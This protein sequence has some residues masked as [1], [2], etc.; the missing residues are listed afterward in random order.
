MRDWYPNIK[1]HFVIQEDPR[2]QS[3]AIYLAREHLTGPMMVVFAD[4]L[5]ETDLSFLANETSDAIAWVKPVDDPRRF[6]VVVLDQQGGVTRL[7]EKPEET[8][9]NLAVVGFYYFRSSKQLISA[10]EEQMRRDTQL[11]GE[12]FLV[13]AVNIMLENGL[14]MR[15]EKVD[16]WLDAGTPEALLE[17]NRYLLDN[18]HS[19]SQEVSDRPGTVIIPP[20]YLHPSAEVENSIIGPHASIGAGARVYSS[21]VRNSILED[22][23][24]V[25]D[26]ILESSLIGRRSQIQRRAGAI[27]AGDNTVVF[28]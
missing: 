16:I 18:G 19:N 22:E 17:T 6:G 28:L 1:S 8:H 21:I 26:V 27:N 3:H 7:I 20:V 25:T 5:I 12:Y 24:Q 4:T 13:D 14:T 2:G 11:E 23:A 10:I 15:T 9:N